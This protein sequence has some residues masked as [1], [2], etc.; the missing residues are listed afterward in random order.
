[1]FVDQGFVVTI[2]DTPSDQPNGMSDQWRT[3]KENVEDTRKILDFLASK[4]AGPI[5]LVGTSR[6]TLSAAHL[7]ASL[8]DQRLTGL[9]LT[10]SMSLHHAES[11]GLRS[12][13]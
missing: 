5:V 13:R 9:A 8:S 10:S 7:A 4:A 1:M 12:S 2:I 6:G 3:G 11:A